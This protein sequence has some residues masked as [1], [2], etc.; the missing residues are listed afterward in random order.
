MPNPDLPDREMPIYYAYLNNSF[1]GGEKNRWDDL[2]N[3]QLV[4]TR[5]D[6]PTYGLIS[7]GRQCLREPGEVPLVINTWRTE[8]TG[9]IAAGSEG[10]DA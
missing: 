7:A 1:N 8:G 10:S 3:A 5:P 2:L 9:V 6:E 4:A